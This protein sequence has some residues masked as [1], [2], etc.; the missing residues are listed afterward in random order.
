MNKS[1]TR[2]P[3]LDTHNGGRCEKTADALLGIQEI[4]LWNSLVIWEP[5]IN[6]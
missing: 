1:H 3:G 5:T 6:H 4:S 2:H